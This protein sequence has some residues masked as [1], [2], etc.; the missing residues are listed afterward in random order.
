MTTI[1]TIDQYTSRLQ[2]ELRSLPDPECDEIISEIKSHL[3]HRDDQG[4]LEE[5]IATLGSPTECAQRFLDEFR[6]E[7]ASLN[8]GPVKTFGTLAAIATRRIGAALGFLISGTLFLFAI[9]FCLTLI[10]EILLPEQT[11]LWINAAN[12]HIA[13]GVVDKQIAMASEEILGRWI[14][15]ISPAL[16][17][18][19]YFLA[20]FIGQY[21]VKRTLRQLRS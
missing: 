17:A 11:G 13:F 2:R 7:R 5:A 18:A 16:A 20:Q 1:V 4:Q 8:G 3:A 12:G 14:I 15:L 19:C 9:A 6:L 21:F 10:A